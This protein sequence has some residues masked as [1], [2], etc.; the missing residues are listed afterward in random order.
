[1]Y[2]K[3]NLDLSSPL[4]A[5][6]WAV[7]TTAFWG[8]IRLEEFLPSRECHFDPSVLPAWSNFGV[9]NDTGTRSLFLPWTKKSGRKGEMVV[10]TRQSVDCDPIN[11]LANYLRVNNA[12]S[13]APICSYLN[14]EGQVVAL[15]TRKLLLI[16]NPILERHTLPAISGHCFRIGGTT[17]LLLK[18]VPSDVV[19]AMGRWMS[20]AFLRYWRNLQ[21]I[22]PIYIELLHPVMS[23]LD[24]R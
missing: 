19:K 15:T 9:P 23:Y 22:A 24:R 16:I 17:A 20:D 11:A 1:M 13:N 8:Q 2:I 6:V 7:T 4:D 12:V 18:G 10:I 5:C 3:A 21:L 14:K